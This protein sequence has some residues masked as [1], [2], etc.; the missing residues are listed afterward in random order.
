MVWTRDR[1]VDVPSVRNGLCSF[2][3]EVRFDT[4]GARK[5]KGRKPPRAVIPLSTQRSRLNGY[6]R[7]PKAAVHRRS[8]LV[9]Q[10]AFHKPGRLPGIVSTALWWVSANRHARPQTGEQLRYN[11]RVNATTGR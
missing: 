4:S 1:E 6:R 2:V 9:T 5:R 10:R 3:R 7:C 11:S 8:P